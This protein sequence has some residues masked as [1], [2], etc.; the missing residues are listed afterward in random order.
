MI[1]HSTASHPT[2]TP[3]NSFNLPIFQQIDVAGGSKLEATL[4]MK[5]SSIHDSIYMTMK[6]DGR[7]GMAVEAC[8]SEDYAEIISGL[9]VGTYVPCS[10]LSTIN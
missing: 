8:D 1:V 10:F 5:P 2:E 7:T 9:F 6:N 4:P 3:F